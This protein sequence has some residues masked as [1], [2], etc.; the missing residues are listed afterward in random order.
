MSTAK[1]IN[2]YQQWQAFL[3]EWPLEKLESLTLDEYYSISSDTGFFQWL[4]THTKD[5]GEFNEGPLSAGIRPRPKDRA[6]NKVADDVRTNSHYIWY[7][8]L[9][10]TPE[11]AFAT[12]KNE[13]LNSV[14]AAQKGDLGSID[15]LKKAPGTLAWKV[16]FL[17]QDQLHPQILPFYTRK[18]IRRVIADGTGLKT[19]EL[20]K[21][22]I[23]HRGDKGLLEYADELIKNKQ[24]NLDNQTNQTL[25]E[26]E[27]ENP[28]LVN[29]LPLNQ[30][31]YGPPGT[32]KTYS[33][34][35]AALRILEPALL[36]DKSVTREKM[37]EAFHG[38]L[39][40]KQIVFCTF[41]QSFS[42]EDFVEGLRAETQNGSLNYHIEDGVFKQLCI[43]AQR[44]HTQEHDPFD[45]AIHKL[46]QLL[47]ENE[48][49]LTMDTV[50]MKAFDVE[51]SEGPTFFIYPQS[52]QSLTQ[53]Y[54]GNMNLVRK[55]YQ[56][57]T[58]DG[59]YNASYVE[60]M[61]NFLKKKCGL[62]PYEQTQKPIGKPEKFVLIIDE[63]N[64][65]NIS[66]IF[67]ELITLIEPSKRAG[68]EEELC[69]SLPYSKELFS[70]PYNV[71]LIGTM[72]SADRSLAGLD[73]ALRRRFV[74]Q[75]MPPRPDL[76]DAV[77]VEGVNI[78][79]LLRTMNERIE[80]LL[81]RDH[82][83]GHAY[84]MPLQK[85]NTIELLASIFRNQ[86]L[87][88]L[89]EYFFE[90]WQRIHWVL[91]D[92]RKANN[93]KF[94]YQAAQNKLALFG[95]VD[96]LPEHTRPWCINSAAFERASAYQGIINGKAIDGGVPSESDIA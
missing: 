54:C 44:G 39:K 9:G 21:R 43:Q 49:R 62:P 2:A 19:E 57:G 94:V 88:L 31:L 93:D 12:L 46:H 96:G 8:I 6:N 27:D 63:I 68:A 67:G 14:Y 1:I 36:D 38:F 82:C 4:M 51:Y 76:L 80:V 56:T 15:A 83:L 30:I 81:D 32:G 13:L 45:Q 35:N 77:E 48:G 22:L 24:K 95:N 60:G 20:H 73:I 75:E 65:G 52:N 66:R 92:H 23:S 33:T 91:N 89:Q 53:G 87:P 74:F 18:Q 58:K 59:I 69:V 40:K 84:F 25:L 86:I 5:I 17:Y 41:H 70:I 34:I 71:Y 50:K 42:Y 16:A 64:R 78:G 26:L 7:A 79:H 47:N 61:L 85:N 10:D 55:L 11:A 29:V 3:N 90:D 28:S 37:I 72:N